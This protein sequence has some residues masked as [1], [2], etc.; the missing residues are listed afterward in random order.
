MDKVSVDILDLGR[1]KVG[2]F[3]ISSYLFP[4]LEDHG[5][6][7]FALKAYQAQS[8][9]KTGYTKGRSEVA[10]SNIKMYAQKGTG[11]A[12]HSTDKAPQFV[13]GGVAFGPKGLQRKVKLNRKMWRRAMQLLLLEKIK[14]SQVWVFDDLT[15]SNKKT[16]EAV[17][18]FPEVKDQKVLFVDERNANLDCSVRNL[19]WGRYRDIGFFTVA[20]LMHSRFL[21]FS[22]NS[23]EKLMQRLSHD[24]SRGKAS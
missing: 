17:K 1:K 23:F 18:L 20:D 7:Y 8:Q 14:N 15:L 24:V 12:R 2:Q 9:K 19:C 21:V 16:K 22:K 6:I 5:D 13:G 4:K 3:D 11:R 10:G